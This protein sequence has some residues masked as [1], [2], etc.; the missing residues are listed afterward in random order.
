MSI[1]SVHPKKGGSSCK[2][3]LKRFRE[4]LVIVVAIKKLQLLLLS[5]FNILSFHNPT[6]TDTGVSVRNKKKLSHTPMLSLAVSKKAHK[7]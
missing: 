5:D 7:G 4:H 1:K 3:M 6:S 2:L